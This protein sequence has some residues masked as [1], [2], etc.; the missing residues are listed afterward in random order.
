[1]KFAIINCQDCGGKERSKPV[2]GRNF[3]ACLVRKIFVK[4]PKTMA[5]RRR[6]A[7]EMSHAQ[8]IFWTFGSCEKFAAVINRFE[9]EMKLN[10]SPVDV[11]GAFL[12][13][14]GIVAIAIY[15]DAV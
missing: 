12:V 4:K 9:I 14:A 7:A 6:D 10:D 8:E 15:D 3:D 11:T 1:M 5:S 13:L 2:D